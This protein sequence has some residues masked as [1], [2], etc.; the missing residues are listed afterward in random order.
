M[1]RERLEEDRRRVHLAA[2]PAR[3]DVEQLGPGHAQEEDR[4]RPV[5][6]V[7]DE[8]EEGRFAPVDVVEDHHEWLMGGQE[9]EKP[10]DGSEAFL[11]A[12]GR[13]RQ[14][15]DV[16]YLSSHDACVVRFDDELATRDCASSGAPASSRPA[17]SFTASST[18][19]NVIPSP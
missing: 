19:Q 15:D 8:I 17:T 9:L 16:G 1:L 10:A 3:T 18:G 12:S 14:A 4:P 11:D 2:A 7:L 5:R 6:E 13:F